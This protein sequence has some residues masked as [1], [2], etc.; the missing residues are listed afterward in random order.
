VDQHINVLRLVFP[1]LVRAR[2]VRAE[3]AD[4]TGHPQEDK[5]LFSVVAKT[6]GSVAVYQL[7][8]IA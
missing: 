2:L 5:I 4:G 7:F 3:K 6:Q 8:A 1:Q